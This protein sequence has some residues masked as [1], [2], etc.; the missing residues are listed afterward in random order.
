MLEQYLRFYIPMHDA[1]AS[2]RTVECSVRHQRRAVIE[3]AIP[4]CKASYISYVHS[5]S[6]VHAVA[7]S[8]CIHAWRALVHVRQP[9]CRTGYWNLTVSILAYL[10]GVALSGTPSV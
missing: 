1:Y 8:M 10:G 6:S 3:L 9:N 5:C 7:S 4:A 2:V